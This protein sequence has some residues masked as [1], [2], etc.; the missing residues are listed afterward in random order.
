[1]EGK[2]EIFTYPFGTELFVHGV[3]YLY[4]ISDTYCKV[5]SALAELRQ[6]G[7]CDQESMPDELQVLLVVDMYVDIVHS[8]HPF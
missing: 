6:E 3:L 5:R 1:M 7:L 4:R 8:R 2:M